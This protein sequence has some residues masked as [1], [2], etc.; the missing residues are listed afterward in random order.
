VIAITVLASQISD[1]FVHELIARPLFW[2]A[3]PV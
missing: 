3:E 1:D 2:L